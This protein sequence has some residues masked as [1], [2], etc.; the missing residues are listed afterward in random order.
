MSKEDS[1]RWSL[2][3]SIM[4]LKQTDKQIKSVQKRFTLL[5]L[6]GEY[7]QCRLTKSRTKDFV[8]GSHYLILLSLV[9]GIPGTT[10]EMGHLGGYN[11][12]F[13]E[14]SEI[15][16]DYVGLFYPVILTVR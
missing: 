7:Y 14:R 12:L 9:Y 1:F 10:V 5:V 4:F 8:S 13:V 11:L 6:S 15:E 3:K 2:T 16:S